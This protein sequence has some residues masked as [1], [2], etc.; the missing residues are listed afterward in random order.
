MKI[1]VI[2][3][4]SQHLITVKKLGKENASTLGFLPEGAFNERAKE[5]QIIIALDDSE[6]CV[7]YILYRIVSRQ[8]KIVHLCIDKSKRNTGAAQM[9]I[10][11]LKTITSDLLGL[12]LKCRRDYTEAT[13]LWEKSRFIPIGESRGRGKNPT[14]LVYWW[15][16]HGH[17]SL[18][19]ISHEAKNKDQIEI[20]VDA[21]VFFDFDDPSRTG[22]EESN[23]L[24]ADWLQDILNISVVDELY[25]EINHSNDANIRKN[26]RE[27]ASH[28]NQLSSDTDKADLIVSEIKAIYV[29]DEARLT[30]RDRSDIRQVAEAVTG[31]AQYFI[32]RDEALL[33]KVISNEIFNRFGLRIMRPSDLV[34]QIDEIRRER[35]YQPARLSG[36]SIKNVLVKSGLEAKLT[37]LF[38]QQ[39]TKTSFQS[40]LR[41]YLSDLS[42]HT[43]RQIIDE[44]DKLLAL[45]VYKK[46][47]D[48]CLEVPL[49]RIYKNKLSPTLARHLIIEAVHNSITENKHFVKITDPFIH[50]EIKT[51]LIEEG[52][53]ETENIWTKFHIKDVLTKSQ[54]IRRLNQISV[55]TIEQKKFIENVND[56]LEK[57]Y[58]NLTAEIFADIE[59]L[60]Y[61]LKISDS[62]LQCFIIPI[63]PQWAKE[64]FDENL[65]NQGLFGA[66]RDLALRKEQI[67][68]RSKLNSNGLKSP[69]RIL[70]YVSKGKSKYAGVGAIR[71]CS[72]IDE[73]IVEKPKIVFNL[74]KRLGIYEW[75]D[76]YKTANQNINNEI[77]AIKFSH[78]QLFSNPVE[79]ERIKKI[80]EDNNHNLQVFSPYRISQEL[81]MKIYIEGMSLENNEN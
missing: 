52:F 40:S 74:F 19:D 28:Y 73:I 32:T 50:S 27:K 72:L 69:A 81:F 77:M 30:N 21:N 41:L 7:G 62:L 43:C 59:K 49:L 44:Q 48:N 75:Q 46:S 14:T 9:L 29:K 20:V 23:A 79:N 55:E 64:L 8:A 13:K 78:T 70:W 38:Q 10:N 16:S 66:K 54:T 71:A 56:L 2:N 11:F 22:F 36:T 35:E 3:L 51:A 76:V 47:N 45:F 6:C 1:E 80:A 26:S 68:Y 42:V 63:Q 34:I 58:F 39:E 25:Q 12:S 67:Y 5:K 37:K 65:A 57:D 4:N 31:D 18:F 60:F 53:L 61:P 24:K 15:F 33:K 17:P